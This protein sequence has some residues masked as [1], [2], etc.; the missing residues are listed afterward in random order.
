MAEYDEDEGDALVIRSATRADIPRIVEVRALVRENQL[1]DPSR[2]TIED[3]CWFID[4]PGIFVWVEDDKIVGFSAADPRDGSIFAL[5]MDEAY[6]GRGIARAL[7]ERACNVLVDAGCPRMW[8]TTWPG[9]RAE[10]FY[11]RA[12]WHV[13]G[14]D[15]GNLVFE[16]QA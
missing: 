15:D 6:E 5:F 1:R 3:I 9:T 7:F 16:K 11:R 10:K 8:L 12:G 13:T 4:N 2:V 14:T